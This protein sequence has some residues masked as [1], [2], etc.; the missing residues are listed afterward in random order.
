MTIKDIKQFWVEKPLQSV[1]IIALVLR[2]LAAIFAQG[3]GM[4][5]DHFLVIEASQSWVDGTD[6]N[7][8]LPQNQVNPQPEGHSFFY[9]GIHF[10][11]FSLFKM[12]GIANPIFK[13]LLIRLLHAFF[14]LLVV[15]YGFKI[16]EKLSNTKIATQA[17]LLL[18]VLWFMPWLSVRNLVEVVCIPFLL[19]GFW[20][21]LN[22]PENKKP[23]LQYL[24]AG[25]IMGLSFSVRFQTLIYVGGAELVLLF[26]KRW[27]EM[28]I[29]GFGALLSIFAIQGI[30]DIFIWK[31]PFAELTEYIIYNI[32]HK[33]EYG[34]NNPFMYFELIMGMLIPPIGILLFFGFFKEW[35][36][37][38]MLFLPTFL[39]FAFH[40][41]FSN[42]Q[43]RFGA[44]MIPFFVILGLIGWNNFKDKSAFW[45]KR[46]KLLKGFWIFF[47]VLNLLLLPVFTFM[48]AKKARIEAIYYFYKNPVTQILV[49]D[50][51]RSEGQMLPCYYAGHWMVMYA[52]PVENTKDSTLFSTL[53]KD[54]RYFKEIY[55]KQYFKFHP[56]V[57]P[58]YILF[59]GN[60]KLEERLANLKPIFPNLTLEKQSEPG[61]IDKIMYKLN[62]VNKNE[63][64]YIY[65]IN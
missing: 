4:H 49:E 53:K 35:K 65:K 52:L 31:R 3:F 2:L 44:T 25:L 45:L 1:V 59:I 28:V 19:A 22:A 26:Q 47:W 24:L 64:I 46:P 13:M 63:T 27:K 42:K 17:G 11:L 29:F 21:L 61:F 16:T 39:F 40:T 5:D 57:K 8:W 48:Y 10:L 58:G 37:Q 6:Y 33:D 50:T 62:P 54:D 56:E 32:K 55:N 30:V 41:L 9:V 12:L 18:A 14:S 60:T 7:N 43:E 15:Y 20:L 51:N 38:L 23:Y 34:T 36:K